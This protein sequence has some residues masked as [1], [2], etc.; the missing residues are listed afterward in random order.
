MHTIILP[1]HHHVEIW[2]EIV[3]GVIVGIT[4]LIVVTVLVLWIKYRVG[5][6]GV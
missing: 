6:R 1:L 3:F 5:N 4:A 2:G